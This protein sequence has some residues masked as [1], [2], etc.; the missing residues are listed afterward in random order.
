MIDKQEIA[1]L[2]Q[3]GQRIREARGLCGFTIH[4]AA[5]LLGVDA[6]FLKRLEYGVIDVDARITLKFIKN[7]SE[8]FDVTT[9]FLLGFAGDEWE[10]DPSVCFQRKV[11]AGLYLATNKRLVEVAVKHEQQH[12]QIEALSGTTAKMLKAVS[13]LVEA[14]E[15]FCE[16]NPEFENLLGSA[17]LVN[18]AKIAAKA[19]QEAQCQLTRCT[20]LPLRSPNDKATEKNRV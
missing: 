17:T 10:R 13:S 7:A 3:I 4:Q 18:R 9:D 20:I 5:R 15:K 14:V 6:G 8:V 1:I 2:Q 16:L 19:T 12:L 11:G